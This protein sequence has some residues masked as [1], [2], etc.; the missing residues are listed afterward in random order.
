MPPLVL[1]RVSAASM[2]GAYYGLIRRRWLHGS[3]EQ[4][5]I[6]M[7]AMSPLMTEGTITRW[8]I[9]EGDAF[10]PGDVLLQIESD[11]ATIDVEAHSPGILGKILLPDGTTN[12]PVEQVIALVAR[13]MSELATLQHLSNPIPSSFNTTSSPLARSINNSSKHLPLMSPRTPS[14]FEMQA[15]GYG[16]RGAHVGGPHGAAPRS[17]SSKGEV[18]G[19]SEYRVDLPPCPSP[20]IKN[21]DPISTGAASWSTST[22]V[23]KSGSHVDDDQVQ[24]DGAAIRRKIVA[25][26]SV[27]CFDEL[28]Y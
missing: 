4:Q 22:S 8:K 6:M 2:R 5:A 16:F 18:D 21:Q 23:Q 28:V 9:K 11:I 17:N 26:L 3:L 14:L 13:D 25:N 27:N 7:P 15:M 24:I 20:G 1:S 19:T 10:V 12:V